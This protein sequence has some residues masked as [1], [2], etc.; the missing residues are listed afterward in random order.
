MTK[1]GGNNPKRRIVGQGRIPDVELDALTVR[2]RYGGSTHHKRNAGDYRFIP[3][4]NPRG[5]KSLCDDLRVILMREAA[6][7]MKNGIKKGMVSEIL[8][9]G[10]PK[11]IWAVDDH[12]EPY[13]AKRGDDGCTYH[14]YRLNE[15]NESLMR[16]LVLDEWHQRRTRSDDD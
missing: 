13:E 9:D 8:P 12:D 1:R 4:S 16:E 14:G 15:A 6:S 11:Y 7:L 2:V 5:S 10:Y 3:P